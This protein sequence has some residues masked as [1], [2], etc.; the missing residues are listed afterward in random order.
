M[1]NSKKANHGVGMLAELPAIISRDGKL[2]QAQV[3]DIVTRLQAIIQAYNGHISIGD[4]SNSSQSGNL[5]GHTKIVSFLNA[6]QDYEVPHGLARK[7]IG[8]L[9]LYADQDDA[10]VRPSNDGS[11]TVERIFVRCNVAG[12]TARFIVV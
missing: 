9:L 10:V 1:A 8:I 6:D 4:G 7:P 2:T 3:E 12:T 11:W 5:D